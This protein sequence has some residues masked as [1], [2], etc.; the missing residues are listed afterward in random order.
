MLHTIIGYADEPSELQA[1]VYAAVAPTIVTLSKLVD[2]RPRQL[3]DAAPTA[4]E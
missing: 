1:P 4:A 3:E 2:R